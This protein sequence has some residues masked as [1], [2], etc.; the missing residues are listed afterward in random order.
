MTR[1]ALIAPGRGAYTEANLGSLSSS[2]PYV[3]RAEELRA[4]YGLSSLV[5]LDRAERFSPSRHLDPVNASALI[6]LASMIDAE[7]AKHEYDI[8]I[9]GGNSMGWYT[10][11]AIA[12]AL[13]FDDA[14]RLVQGMAL[15]QAEA[16]RMHQGGQILYP[17]C[18]D[19]W[20]V[21]PERT[22]ALERA[23]T[24]AGSEAYWSIRLGGFAVLA[25]TEAGLAT[26]LREL[27]PVELGRGKFPFRLAQHG[28]Y[29]TPL[30]ATVADEAKTELPTLE[31]R[32]PQIP[33]VDGS[34]RVHTPWSADP[35]ELREYTLGA[36]IVE[37]FD[38]TASV[39][40][41]LREWAPEQLVLPGPGN[42]LG[43]IVG[44]I[45]VSERW[46]GIDSKT[47]FTKAQQETTPIL[48][49]MGA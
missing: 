10:A 11:L 7:R 20:Q 18:D 37:P 17:L 4:R 9:V 39:R 27:P 35:D 26:L 3:Q 2:L 34:G 41:A 16:A 8:A 29:H 5:E 32:K 49:S 44:Q 21:D 45:L 6:W 1:C 31:W 30:C 12:G 25:G 24:T 19:E 46:R 33:L 36:Q 13:S 28:P 47:A 15:L 23:L 42:P 22:A 48:V 40:V 43:G 14:F 38:F